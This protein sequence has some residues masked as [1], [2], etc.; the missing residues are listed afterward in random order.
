MKFCFMVF[1]KIL[2]TTLTWTKNLV[3]YIL[4]KPYGWLILA[5]LLA[6]YLIIRL[7]DPQAQT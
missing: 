7:Y 5:A 1:Y 3:V 6:A 2:I 4:H